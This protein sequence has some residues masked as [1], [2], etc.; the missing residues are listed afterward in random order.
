MIYFE[1]REK[2]WGGSPTTEQLANGIESVNLVE[3]SEETQPDSPVMSQAT[4]P[5]DKSCN[6]GARQ[7]GGTSTAT[8]RG[9]PNT[10]L[11][12]TNRTN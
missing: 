5:E 4:Q 11:R 8:R 9:S 3:Q 10:T 7:Q 6:E 12:T 1:L 2:I